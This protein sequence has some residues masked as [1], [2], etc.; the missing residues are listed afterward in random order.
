MLSKLLYLLIPFIGIAFGGLYQQPSHEPVSNQNLK[1]ISNHLS[2]INFDAPLSLDFSGE[3]VPLEVPAVKKKLDREIRKYVKYYAGSALTLK[4][5]NR[6][7]ETFLS[8]LRSQ[9]VPE[10][11]F[12]LSVAESNLANV[13]SPVGAQGFWQFMPQTAREYGLEVSATVDERLHPE[14]ATYAACRYLLSSYRQFGNWSLVAAS[15]NMGA[16]GLQ[17]TIERQ[18]NQNYFDLKLNRETGQYLYRI[19]G[20]KCII[21]QP[22]RYGFNLDDR[23]LYYP[24]GY[25][26]V[27]VSENIRDLRTFAQENGTTWQALRMM[28]PWLISDHLNVQ[29]GKTYEIR[30]PRSEVFAH[31]LMVETIAEPDS[32]VDMN[33]EE[34]LI[35]ISDTQQMS[36]QITEPENESKN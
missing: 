8:I 21:E 27:R 19:L 23:D 12:Y 26:V 9:G 11:F 35:G 18:C 4:R 31:E 25:K 14:R 5:A 28:N 15:Y 24:L 2:V 16:P 17:R 3:S 30:I 1:H 29:E 34:D 7:K 36:E 32:S 20:Y 13:T 10:D 33:D 6:Y 22:E